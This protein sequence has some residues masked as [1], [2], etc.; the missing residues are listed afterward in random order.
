MAFSH[1]FIFNILLYLNFF[2]TAKFQG[3]VS[4]DLSG[5]FIINTAG[6]VYYSKKK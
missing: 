2:Y 4:E 6:Q 5:R 3:F 1:L